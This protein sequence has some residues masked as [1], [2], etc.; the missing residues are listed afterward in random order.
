MIL[1]IAARPWSLGIIDTLS[2][3][4]MCPRR[5]QILSHEAFHAVKVLLKS[6]VGE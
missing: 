5:L 6:K 2:V 3:E 4:L 1:E